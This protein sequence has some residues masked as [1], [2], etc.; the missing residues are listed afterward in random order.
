MTIIAC[1]IKSNQ[2]NRFKSKKKPKIKS[3]KSELKKKITLEFCVSIKSKLMCYWI[4]FWD[5]HKL[6]YPFLNL[7]WLEL[8]SDKKK[9]NLAFETLSTSFILCYVLLEAQRLIHFYVQKLWTLFCVEMC[10]SF[11]AMKW[12]FH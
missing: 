3:I 5:T 7:M 12:N 6:C 2:K 8:L 1:Q 11:I 4:L 10:L 9:T